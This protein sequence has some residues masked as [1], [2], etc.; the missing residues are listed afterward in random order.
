MKKM[1]AIESRMNESE[2][3]R[4]L[5]NYGNLKTHETP[6]SCNTHNDNF[7]DFAEFNCSWTN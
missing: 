6:L 3:E 5:L 7:E 1:R 2:I 4:Q